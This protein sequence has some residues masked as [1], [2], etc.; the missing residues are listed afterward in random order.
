M[1]GLT[2][3]RIVHY[4]PAGGFNKNRAAVITH[5]WGDNG[6]VNLYVFPDGSYE[7]GNL[8]PTSVKYDET[9]ERDTWHW[10]PKA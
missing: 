4:V 5:V 9:G 7:M 3:G 10:I 6:T 8:T 2:E 1:E